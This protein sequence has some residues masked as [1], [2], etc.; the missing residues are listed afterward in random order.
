MGAGRRTTFR[1]AA[2]RAICGVA[3]G[4]GSSTDTIAAFIRLSDSGR[5]LTAVKGPE[6]QEFNMRAKTHKGGS[7]HEIPDENHDHHATHHRVR[8]QTSRSGEALRSGR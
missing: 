1:T 6:R 8:R 3:A 5:S 7:H 2:A 4:T